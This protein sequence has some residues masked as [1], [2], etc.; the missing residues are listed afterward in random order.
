MVRLVSVQSEG[1]KG[2]ARRRFERSRFFESES[3]PGTNP[4][5][6][7]KERTW[8][9]PDETKRNSPRL[10]AIRPLLTT[11]TA[12]L[13]AFRTPSSGTLASTT[14]TASCNPAWDNVAPGPANFAYSVPNSLEARVSPPDGEE[15]EEEEEEE[16]GVVG[17]RQARTEGKKSG[18]R[19]RCRI[20]PIRSV[21]LVLV[22][23]LEGSVPVAVVPGK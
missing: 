2:R 4:R 23:E 19:Y 7:E 10:L 18:S 11:T 14:P 12:S 20:G 6:T 17:A 5:S 21:V 9:T 15:E 8:R 22:A 13:T 16:E 1:E 3:P